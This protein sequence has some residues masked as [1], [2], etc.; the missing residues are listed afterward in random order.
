MPPSPGAALVETIPV[1]GFDPAGEPEIRRF[2]D[3]SLQVVFDFMPPSFVEDE[4][5][6]VDL[7]RYRKLDEE[8]ARATGTDVV[9]D[10]REFFSIE[11]PRED[12]VERLRQFLAAY[13]D[14]QG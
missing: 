4:S 2:S 12:T 9:W 8:M 5:G 7:G 14:G 13:H 10:D 1:S 11:H 6:W 3:G